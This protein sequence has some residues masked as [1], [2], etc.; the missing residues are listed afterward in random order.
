MWN[1]RSS[2]PVVRH[3]T[4][5]ANT[6]TGGAAAFGNNASAPIVSDCTF[7]GNAAGFTG[8]A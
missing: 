2:A 6:S 3:C 5:S 7:L 1:D 4:F 8:A